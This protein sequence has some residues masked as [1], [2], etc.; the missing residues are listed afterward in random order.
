MM[1]VVID[2]AVRQT[3]DLSL[4]LAELRGVLQ[5]AETALDREVAAVEAELRRAHTLPAIKDLGTLRRQRDF[6]WQLGVDPTKV[7][8]ASEAL[9]RRIVQG[10][11]L[12]RI[13]PVV[14]AYN[15]ASVTTLL[16]FSAFDAAKVEPPVRVRFAEAGEEVLLI[17][18]RKKRLSGHEL[19][20]TDASRVLCVYVHGDADATKV[21]DATRDVLL[22][23][24]GVP[25]VSDTE[26]E[27]GLTVAARYILRFA[28][29]ELRGQAIYR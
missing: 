2:S 24:Y 5:R 1:R 23:A 27:G 18:A 12:P 29:G 20:L 25:G 8:P 10:K 15:L 7:R 26:L 21:T 4:G 6:F 3:F 9:L 22:V 13:S 17:G 11:G 28:G 14:D 19:V 16:T